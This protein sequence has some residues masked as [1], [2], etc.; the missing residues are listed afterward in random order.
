MNKKISSIIKL[1]KVEENKLKKLIEFLDKNNIDFHVLESDYELKKNDNLKQALN[2]IRQYIKSDEA[3][4]GE[5]YYGNII[6][7][8]EDFCADNI[9][10]IIDKA[11]SS[12]K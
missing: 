9:L 6:Y 1:H 5:D 12:D 11:I 3:T 2:E 10:Q 8:R 4:L 7:L